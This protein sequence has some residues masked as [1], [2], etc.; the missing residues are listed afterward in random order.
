MP[1]LRFVLWGG[2]GPCGAGRID[3]G[4]ALDLYKQFIRTAAMKARMCCAPWAAF[5]SPKLSIDVDRW[6]IRLKLGQ[7][8]TLDQERQGPGNRMLPVFVG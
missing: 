2:N 8:D 5:L 7:A 4:E 6:R 3:C 1:R